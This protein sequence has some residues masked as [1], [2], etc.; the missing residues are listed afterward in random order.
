AARAQQLATPSYRR[1]LVDSWLDLLIEVR[2]QRTLFDPS[3][4]LVR[5]RVFA[6]EA[7]IR[8]LA[9]A[10]MSPLPTV[11]GLAMSVAML[12][13]GS[14]PLFNAK[15]NTTLSA[16]LERIVAALNPLTPFADR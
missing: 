6:A 14:G 9:D 5:S 2:R 16:S 10:L 4:P 3:V 15:S 12:R 1:G 11:R 13:D 8:A 7:Q